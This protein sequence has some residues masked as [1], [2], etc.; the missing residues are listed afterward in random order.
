MYYTIKFLYWNVINIYFTLGRIRGEKPFISLCH[1]IQEWPK[2]SAKQK[3]GFRKLY[4]QGCRCRVSV[5]YPRLVHVF[6]KFSLRRYVNLNYCCIYTYRN[7]VSLLLFP[8]LL[9]NFVNI[10][11]SLILKHLLIGYT[12]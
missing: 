7:N 6:T 8:Y 9:L 3:K 4:Q 10:I 11:N 2:L 12:L 5:F 1:F